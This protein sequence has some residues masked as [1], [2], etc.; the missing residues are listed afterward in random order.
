MGDKMEIKQLNFCQDCVLDGH[1]D[2]KIQQMLF[3][4]PHDLSF[5]VNIG[6]DILI[7][8]CNCHERER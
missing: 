8:E 4:N 5:I 1:M 2:S 7:C 6:H 3:D